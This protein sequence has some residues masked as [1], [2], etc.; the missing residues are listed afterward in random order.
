MK[1]KPLVFCLVL[2]AFAL[3]VLIVIQLRSKGESPRMPVPEQAEAGRA[4]GTRSQSQTSPVFPADAADS[5]NPVERTLAS[6]KILDTSVVPLPQG[7]WR[8]V[9]LVK[10]EIQPR[11]LRAEEDWRQEPGTSQWLCVRR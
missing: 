3:S 9:R 6:A 7:G 10:S 1:L 4:S 5:S 8:R 11:L 2:C